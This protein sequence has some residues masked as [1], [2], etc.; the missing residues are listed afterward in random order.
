MDDIRRSPRD[1]SPASSAAGPPVEVIDTGE[2]PAFGAPSNRGPFGARDFGGGR[3][4]VYGCSPSCLIVSLTVSLILSLL[5][6][7]LLNLLF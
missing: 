1:P 7:V 3:V 5:L 6:T 4:R 2:A